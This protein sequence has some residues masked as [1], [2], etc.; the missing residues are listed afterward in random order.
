MSWLNSNPG[1]I[2][3]MRGTGNVNSPHYYNIE[4]QVKIANNMKWTAEAGVMLWVPDGA[5]GTNTTNCVFPNGTPVIGQLNTYVAHVEISGFSISG[6]CNNQ[7][8]VLGYAHGVLQSTGS[9]V[10]RLFG[11]K[12]VRDRLQMY[13]HL[14]P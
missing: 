13:R 12:G 2:L 3:I 14:Y 5:C 4:G 9:G 1:N 6:N 7:S 11:F 8:T 10:E